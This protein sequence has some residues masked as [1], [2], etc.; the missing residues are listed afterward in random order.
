MQPQLSQ[1]AFRGNPR[2]RLRGFTI[3]EVLVSLVILSIGLL[4]IGKLVL[5]S[6]HAND[7]AYMRSQATELAYAILDD[8]RSNES[9][10]VAHSYD[11]VSTAAA[12]NPGFSCTLP[13]TCTSSN[14]A[15]YDV[16]VWKQ[17]LNASSGAA[18]P[19]A[20]PNGQGSVATSF[21]GAVTTAVVTVSWDDSA[22]QSAFAGLSGQQL[23]SITLQTVIK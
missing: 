3:V 9:G 18:Q 23:E 21:N 19:G 16:Y 14:L 15:L 1:S 12:V 10:A 20:L 6:A 13:T 2:N 8:M 11:T 4:G 22:A 5:Y 7:S 17:R